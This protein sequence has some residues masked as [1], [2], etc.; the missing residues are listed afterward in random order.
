MKKV[1][2]CLLYVLHFDFSDWCSLCHEAEE[3]EQLCDLLFWRWCSQ[4]RRRTCSIQFRCYFELSHYFF[5]VGSIYPFSHL[6]QYFHSQ[7]KLKVYSNS[8]M[9]FKLIK[10][11][12]TLNW[13]YFDV[14]VLSWYFLFWFLLVFENFGQATVTL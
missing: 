8:K 7:K 13:F 10:V 1:W 12:S 9:Y 5:L 11:N 14:N 6:L 4:R 2:V 3:R